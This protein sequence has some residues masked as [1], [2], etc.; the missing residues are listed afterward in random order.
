MFDYVNS[1][2]VMDWLE[3]KL[4]LES[5]RAVDD[6]GVI[7][8]YPVIS[9]GRAGDDLLMIIEGGMQF[10]ISIRKEAVERLIQW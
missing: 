8:A 5:V 3:E 2:D 1:E 10:R 7:F 9:V 6:V 4:A